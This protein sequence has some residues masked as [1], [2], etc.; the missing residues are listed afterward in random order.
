MLGKKVIFAIKTHKEWAA[1]NNAARKAI[2]PFSIMGIESDK[3][4]SLFQDTINE[5]NL[6]EYGKESFNI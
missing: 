5:F 2:C 4:R 6:E 1:I 3:L